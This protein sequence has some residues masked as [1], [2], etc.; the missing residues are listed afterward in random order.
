M[1]FLK[2]ELEEEMKENEEIEMIIRNNPEM[3]MDISSDRHDQ[4]MN[5]NINMDTYTETN[6]K[7]DI[8]MN[9]NKLQ[10]QPLLQHDKEN[11]FEIEF[12]S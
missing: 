2:K 9:T 7:M 3:F 10:L 8:D 1:D 4:S 11:D 6:R 12:L 5:V